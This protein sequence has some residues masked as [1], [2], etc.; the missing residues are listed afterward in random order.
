MLIS[1]GRAGSA[2]AVQV[3][4][5]VSFLAALPLLVER[6]GLTGA[7]G[8]LLVAEFGL[9]V[10]FLAMLMRHGR[11]RLKAKPVVDDSLVRDALD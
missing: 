5:S 7:G 6:F 4:V 8:G 11:A 9:A 2:V 10:G 3:V 1:F